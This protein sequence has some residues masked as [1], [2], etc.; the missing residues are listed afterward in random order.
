M[1]PSVVTLF[2]TVVFL[3]FVFAYFY[4]KDRDRYV[5]IWALAWAFFALRTLFQIVAVQ[6]GLDL[7]LLRLGNQT[8]ALAN[9][10]FLLWGT[11]V[12]AGRPLPRTWTGLLLLC[13][14]WTAGAA[15]APV[16]FGWYSGPVFLILGLV[17]IRAGWVLLALPSR[18][19]AGRWL[20]GGALV[21]WGLHKLDYPFLR[22]VEW[23]A[24]WG[25]LLATL[26]GL[27]VAVGMLLAHFER[28]RGALLDSERRFRHLV[29]N[30]G[31]GIFV[32][33]LEG[34]ILEA[35]PAA[36]RCTGYRREDLLRLTVADL[37]AGIP[38][39]LLRRQWQALRDGRGSDTVEGFMRCRDGR[40]VPVEIRLAYFE[41]AGEGRVI[42]MVRDVAARKAAADRLAAEKERLEVTLRGIGD[43]VAALDGSG[44]VLYLNPVAERLTGWS[45]EEA[46]GRPA[47]E[48]I[49]LR[50]PEDG[51]MF[52]DGR[53]ALDAAL[54]RG[55]DERAVVVSRDGTERTVEVHGALL[56]A[57][58]AG[59]VLVLHDT[60]EKDRMRE[61][62]LRA[63]KLESLGILA[64]GIAHD[65]NNLLTAILGNISL[66]KMGADPDSQVLDRLERAEKATLRARDLTQQLLT[67]AKGGA[68]VRRAASILDV[69]RDSADFSLRGS[70]VRYQLAAPD[71]LWP[72]D[73]DPGQMSQV[74]GNIMINGA[75]VMPQGGC[76]R[77]R[78]E[79]LPEAAAAGLPLDPGRYVR[80]RI[81]DQGCGIAPRDLPRIFDPYFTTKENGTGLGLATA[82]SIVRRHGGFIEVESEV[83]RGTAFILYLPAAEAPVE[84]EAGEEAPAE[85][86]GRILVMDDEEVV[87]ACAL[88]MLA[89]LGYE[90]AAARDGAEAVRLYA[91]A[92]A[93]GK[94]FDAVVL[95]LTV[96]GGM[97]GKEA[98]QRLREIDP[99]VRA[100]ASSGYSTDPVMGDHEAHGFAAVIPKPYRT[101]ELAAV[102]RR[103]LGRAAADREGPVQQ[104][105]PGMA[106]N[107]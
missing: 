66:A 27:A 37:E 86:R 87:R 1:L 90:A 107:G 47:H 43:G 94:P 77:I 84:A 59:A 71:D 91:E 53:E 79:N 76:I 82:H 96:P 9:G 56:G 20:A 92:R 44:R 72:V 7:P 106:G 10:F 11:E 33:D 3:T 102:L 57:G 89:T 78:C 36:C 28:A 14:L 75:Q 22:P 5:G 45:R 23:F 73:V 101:A 18:Y 55:L 60:T 42:A 93:A 95:D 63:E 26:C 61:S 99:A 31:D 65:F 25:F 52:W 15:F 50:R 74:I 104:V 81:E 8:A 30:A 88:D 41:H 16:S 24:P 6:A 98:V 103:V 97:G 29:E 40:R 85:G 19:R 69:I 32:H 17:Y 58:A 21:L 64:G 4:H 62:L 83:G 70:N 51:G 68:P 48:V 39:D 2:A 34:R 105:L 80:I 13:L 100:V 46:A 35:N 54:E 67:F 38:P 49:R 12:F